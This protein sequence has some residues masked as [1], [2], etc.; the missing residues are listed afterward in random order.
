[1]STSSSDP[2]SVSWA[3]NSQQ[4]MWESTHQQVSV[5][6]AAG[7][8]TRCLLLFLC[9]RPSLCPSP[10]WQSVNL[11]VCREVLV[12]PLSRGSSFEM[13]W[14]ADTEPAD[15]DLLFEVGA[16]QSHKPLGLA[17]ALSCCIMCTSIL[18]GRLLLKKKLNEE[19][20]RLCSACIP[21]CLAG[22][23]WFQAVV[24]I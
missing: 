9:L 4:A 10:Y 19:L 1:M 23:C 3:S 5:K 14:W 2:G 11:H 13:R 22:R 6:S 20:T 8:R 17:V 21:A 12:G 16:P 15:P 7:S 18:T 24:I